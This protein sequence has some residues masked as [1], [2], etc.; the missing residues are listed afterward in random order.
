MAINF[1]GV[2]LVITLDSGVTEVDVLTDIYAPWKTWLLSDS[3]NRGFPQAFRSAG[4]DPLTDNVDA[5][6]YIFLNNSVGWRIRPPE[7]DITIYLTGNLAVEDTALP[8]IVPTVGNF[9]AA[10]LGLQP[11]SQ[12][13]TSGSGVTEQ[14]KDD[15]AD[16]VMDYVMEDG[17]TF[18]EGFRLIRA[19]IVGLLSKAGS[20]FRFRD[21]ADTKDRIVATTTTEGERTS[22]ST[23][24]T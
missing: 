7:E 8:A 11:V 6:S 16:R 19:G 22:V 20:V 24:G 13:V 1:D 4:G 14:D 2:N 18:A 9:T 3:A 15:I 23:D 10:I 21:K 5:G 17:E 12:T